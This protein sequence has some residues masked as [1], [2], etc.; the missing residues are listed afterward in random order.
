MDRI[1]NLLRRG[2]DRNVALLRRK[3]R[4]RERL[5]SATPSLKLLLLIVGYSWMLILPSEYL[6]RETK[7]D[8]N[9]LQPGHV[10]TYW[11]WGDVHK[12]DTYLAQLESLRDSNSS[13][14]QV[15]SFLAE[16]F[17]KLGIPAATQRY[18]FTTTSG[19]SSGTNAYAVLSSPR[20]SGAEAMLISA[21]VISR[22]GEGDGTP[23]L[24]GISTVLALASFL[25]KYSLWAK[26][27]IFVISDGYLEGMQAW[28]TSYHKDQQ[29]NL[30]AEPLTLGSS[31]IWTALNIDYPG[32]SFSHLGVFF[33][34]LNGRLPNQD[35]IKSFEM[36]STYTGGVPIVLYDHIDPRS[37][38]SP[39]Y[40]PVYLPSWLPDFL[41]TSQFVR[42][43]D[44]RLKNIVRHVGYQARGRA[45]GVHGLLHRYRIDAF[46]IFALPAT[47]P[48]GFHAI[49]RIIESTMRTM[50][51]LLE[52]LHASFFFYLLVGAST[53][54]KIG[55]YLPSAVIVS[56]AMM[57]GG[58]YEW[59]DAYWFENIS[60]RLTRSGAKEKPST[61]E[62]VEKWDHR[63]RPVLQAFLI[64]IGTH[65]VGI[66]LFY[67]RTLTVMAQNDRQ[68]SLLLFLIMS[69]TP[70]PAL[71][72]RPTAP[73]KIAP[74]WKVLKAF[75]LFLA[76]TVIS[77]TSVLNFSLAASMAVA[78]GIP[79]LYNTPATTPIGRFIKCWS[80]CLLA[81][82][83][84]LLSEENHTAIRNWELFGTWFAPF[85]PVVYTP[86]VLQAAIVS[87]LSP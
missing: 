35:L 28:I 15:A 38:V 8:E 66:A 34:G 21:S 3:Q 12:A 20:T 6:G 68:T 40:K 55:S 77:I 70:L 39:S 16:E 64:L 75:N 23:N 32:H 14:S 84:L 79:L 72:V 33:E 87:I 9:A 1:L 67:A 24:R 25:K 41:T 82:G 11:N 44:Y 60:I 81:F 5:W 30:L 49:G 63:H 19:Q 65:L 10:H 31:V 48:H 73:N 80:Y 22:T 47:G 62:R 61:E 51:N 69:V 58:L 83:W 78:L 57:F 71:H 42:E 4:F 85:I 29:T 26:D 43:Y 74:V 86:L 18:M 46:T 36:I 54:L 37:Q 2:G 45:S 7:R 13:S 52:R 27:I 59:V 50:N 56:T 76:S 53:F 17:R